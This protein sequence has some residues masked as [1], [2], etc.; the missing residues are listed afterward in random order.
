MPYTKEL[1]ELINDGAP[2]LDIDDDED[3]TANDND[4]DVQEL[5]QNADSAT[6]IG[7]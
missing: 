6:R 7:A 5:D 4:A 3:E 1:K 2:E